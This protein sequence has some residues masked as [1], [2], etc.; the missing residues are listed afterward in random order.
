MDPDEAIRYLEIAALGG[1]TTALFQIALQYE[2]K[3]LGP[4]GYPLMLRLSFGGALGLI[5]FGRRR[6][7]TWAT[8][9]RRDRDPSRLGWIRVRMDPRRV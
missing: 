4:D 5:H 1:Y 2:R 9:T 3:S 7:S 8:A 6:G